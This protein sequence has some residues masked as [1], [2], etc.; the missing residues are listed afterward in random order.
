MTSTYREDLIKGTLPSS[1]AQLVWEEYKYR[2]EHIWKT[3]FR[4]TGSSVAL[5]IVPY[6]NSPLLHDLGLWVIAPALLAVF[7]VLFTWKRMESELKALDRV[8][9]LH[10][11][12]QAKCWGFPEPDAAESGSTFNADLRLYLLSLF[13]IAVFNCLVIPWGR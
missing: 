4:S 6:I 1:E 11:E 10:Q 5:G 3:V 13:F 8:K 2:H 12:R 7:L 9:L